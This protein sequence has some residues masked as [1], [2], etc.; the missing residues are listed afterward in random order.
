MTP[1]KNVYALMLALVI[2]LSGCFGLGGGDAEAMGEDDA[3]TVINNYYWNNTTDI[4]EA[5]EY[6]TQT[7]SV[8]AG[9]YPYAHVLSIQQAPGEAINL[10]DAFGRV[11]VEAFNQNITTQISGVKVYSNCTNG[12]MWE[13]SV[14]T[15]AVGAGGQ[16]TLDIWLAGAGVEC[17]HQFVAFESSYGANYPHHEAQLGLIYH[18]VPVTVV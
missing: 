2:V 12:M 18:R 17:S 13:E 10:L 16:A 14:Y 4:Q 9:N 5:P 3:T 8:D 15:K 6:L 1:V 11:T 7:G